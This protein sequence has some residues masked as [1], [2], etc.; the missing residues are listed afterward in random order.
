MRDYKQLA[1]ETDAYLNDFFS[2]DKARKYAKV[3]N[4]GKPRK[5]RVMYVGRKRGMDGYKAIL[6]KRWK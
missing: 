5:M 1:V 6:L 3:W 2:S 4:K